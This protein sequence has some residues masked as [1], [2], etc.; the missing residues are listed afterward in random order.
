MSRLG[1]VEDL[2]AVNGGDEVGRAGVP[3]EGCG[4]MLAA[5]S[6]LMVVGARSPL[7]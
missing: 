2:T 4:G 1:M 6:R 7:T 5:R 3:S